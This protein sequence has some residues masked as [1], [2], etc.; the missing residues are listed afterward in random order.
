MR[1]ARSGLAEPSQAYERAVAQTRFLVEVARRVAEPVEALPKGS[2]PAVLCALYRDAATFALLAQRAGHKKT[3]Q[4]IGQSPGLQPGQPAGTDAGS[5]V[6][7]DAGLDLRTLWAGA[8]RAKLLEAAGDE[9]TLESLHH[10]LVER[11]TAPALDATEPDAANA[12]KFV[13][14]LLWD[15]DA[16][17]RAVERVQLQ[18]WT[19]VTLL[20]GICLVAVFGV[21]VLLRGPNLASEKRFKTSSSYPP[22]TAPNKCFDVLLHTVQEQNPWADFD[23]G[24]VKMVHRVE[25]TNR[26]DC[27]PGRS[28]PLIVELSLD[29]RQWT[30]VARRDTDFSTWVAKF[31]KRRARYVRL[32]VPA[33]AILNLDDVVVR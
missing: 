13:E 28:I 31:P 10:V 17:I 22:C 26:S 23:L 1:K 20:A 21:R 18:R 25:V 16:P 15:L 12:R 8:P 3:E 27:C 11:S 9:A 19:R 30:Q 29:D 4:D 33:F 6:D 14:A 5:R 7:S 32:R 2:R 24:A